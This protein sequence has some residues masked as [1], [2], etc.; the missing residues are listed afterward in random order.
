MPDN[1]KITIKCQHL[2]CY[3]NIDDDGHSYPNNCANILI[4]VTDRECRQYIER[5]RAEANLA[6]AVAQIKKERAGK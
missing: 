5:E 3:W 1:K 2:D 6:A 4:E